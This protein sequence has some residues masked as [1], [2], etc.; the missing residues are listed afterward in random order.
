MADRGKRPAG[1]PEATAETPVHPQ[2][3]DLNIPPQ[4]ATSTFWPSN[5]DNLHRPR[6]LRSNL[7]YWARPISS[8]GSSNDPED[9]AEVFS[10]QASWE[11][12]FKTLLSGTTG[13]VGPSVSTTG[14]ADST[15]LV[16][17]QEVLS[18]F[19]SQV[20]ESKGLDLLGACL[21]DLG[22]DGQMSVEAIVRA[23]S[24]LERVRE[25]FSVLENA[26]QAKQDLKAALAVQD[27]LHPKIDALKAKGEALADLDRQI[28]ELA[29]RRSAIAS[30]LVK[31]FESGGKDCLTE[32]AASAKLIEQLKMDKKNWQAE[33]IMGKV[34]WLELKALLSTLLPSSP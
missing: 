20:L 25:T 17:V 11:A 2:D 14:P 12:E 8:L 28:A 32:Y 9:M 16:R 27:A 18:L 15:A 6:E 1:K 3:Q 29:K 7:R 23:L 19:T 4:E 34:R 33:V 21:N 10:R 31:D 26:F 22:A 30:E 24:A 5:V 13:A